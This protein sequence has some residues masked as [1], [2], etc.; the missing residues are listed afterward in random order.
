MWDNTNKLM[1]PPANE[2]DISQAVGGAPGHDS[3]SIDD[4]CYYGNINIWA[5]YKPV[6]SSEPGSVDRNTIEM[7]GFGS[8]LPSAGTINGLV[9]LYDGGLN[10]WTYL[11]TGDAVARRGRYYD[12]FRVVNGNLDRNNPGY[13]G[14]A[15]NPFGGSFAASPSTVD[16]NGGVLRVEQRRFPPAGDWPDYDLSITDFNNLLNSSQQML[17]YG[18]VI[19]GAPGGSAGSVGARLFGNDSATIGTTRGKESLNYDLT[20]T[21]SAFQTLGD[22]LVYPCL[23]NLPLGFNV[24]LRSGQKLFPIPGASPAVITIVEDYIVIVVTAKAENDVGSNYSVQWTVTIYNYNNTA[25]TLSDTKARFRLPGKGFN[26]P[27]IYGEAEVNLGNIDVPANGSYRYPVRQS[28]IQALSDRSL[29]QLIVGGMY[30]N[31]LK[32]G[33]RDFIVPA[34]PML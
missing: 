4:L 33:Y 23:S 1:Y 28:A 19:K 30:V 34:E 24:S 5:K 27:M 12:F 8:T 18:C 21:A 13:H 17:Y 22:Y 2:I 15:P 6:R 14:S 11:R 26:D 20:L 31:E 32:T 3:G 25:I 16:H 29:S 7:L 10:G 9:N